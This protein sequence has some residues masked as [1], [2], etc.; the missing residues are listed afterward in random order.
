ML[1]GVFRFVLPDLA[2]HF[3]IR[4]LLRSFRIARPP[5]SRAPSWDLLHVLASLRGAPFEPLD[6]VSLRDLT[7]KMLF[8]LALATARRVGELQSLSSTV[9]FSAG[10]I[11]LSYLLLS[12]H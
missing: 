12:T 11:Y 2:D 7:R 3:V 10:D 4:D 1:S 9:S 8:L 5:V 6:T